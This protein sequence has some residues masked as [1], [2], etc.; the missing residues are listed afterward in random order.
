M[1]FCF[2]LFI[3]CFCVD[4][5]LSHTTP[6]CKKKSNPHID[7]IK[8]IREFCKCLFRIIY[9]VHSSFFEY[10]NTHYV[11][12]L[13]ASKNFSRFFYMVKAFYTD[14]HCIRFQQIGFLIPKSIAVRIQTP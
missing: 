8:Q 2:S 12:L 13:W 10:T 11:D 7:K 14:R 1:K 6:Q 5:A 4:L 9:F 3:G